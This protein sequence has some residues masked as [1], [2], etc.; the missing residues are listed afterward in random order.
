MMKR[1]AMECGE[2]SYKVVVCPHI[3]L[4]NPP[5]WLE[6]L[7]GVWRDEANL[8]DSQVHFPIK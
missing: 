6:S 2:A 3:A 5:L 7:S 8:L 4:K 1:D